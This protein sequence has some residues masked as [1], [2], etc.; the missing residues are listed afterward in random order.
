MRMIFIGPPGAGKG[1]QAARLV[2]RF[3]IPHIST[4]DMFRA[5]V[6]A[7]TALGQ[8]ADEHMKGGRLVPDE[9]TIAMLLERVAEPDA[10][11][12]F[13]L[14]GFPRT[15]PQA[16]ALDAALGKAGLKLD[17]VLV[18]E[19]PDDLIVERIVG[20]RSDPDTGRIYHLTFDP[21]PAD[22]VDRLVH[23]KDDTE[24]ACRTRL[25]TYHGQTAPIIPFYEA[26]G[27]V[28]KVNGVG[29]ADDVTARISAATLT[30]LSAR[31]QG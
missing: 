12:G 3:K 30:A 5:A 11:D 20:R 13:M 4:G 8:Q 1:T 14:D 27:L 6:K 15:V 29:S 22:I 19:V 2:E 23:R 10:R 21:P 25:A 24:E 7:G 28:R 16:E 18:L 26:Q 31:R 17:V 9:L